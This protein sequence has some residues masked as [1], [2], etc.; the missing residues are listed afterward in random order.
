[1]FRKIVNVV[2]VLALV[3]AVFVIVMLFAAQAPHETAG[4]ASGGDAGGAAYLPETGAL[5]TSGAEIY[6]ARCAGCHGS[7]GGGGTGPRLAGKVE[8]DFPDIEDQVAFV[9]KGKGGMPG[10]GGSLSDADLRLVVEYT[11]TNLGG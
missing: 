4:A 1:M 2:E 3:A 6:S 10:F 8:D 7:D 5:P 9:A 11:R